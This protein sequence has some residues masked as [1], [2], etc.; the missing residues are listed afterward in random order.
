MLLEFAAFI[1]LRIKKPELHRPYKVPLQTFGA[2]MLCLPPT[3]LLILVMCLASF[4]TYL[5]SAAV[6]IVGFISYPFVIHA[7]ASDWLLFNKEQSATPSETDVESRQILL[8]QQQHEETNEASLG[9][10]SDNSLLT[11]QVP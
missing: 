7:K 9:I 2:V 8:Q 3:I 1:K 11:E 4:K 6:M 10:H 5:V